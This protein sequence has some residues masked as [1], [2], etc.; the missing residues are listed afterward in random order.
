[1]NRK[2]SVGFMLPIL[3]NNSGGV[4]M[5]QYVEMTIEEA[6]KRC[7]KNK[8]VLVAIQDL[9]DS[10]PV[11]LAFVQKDK[12][13]YPSIFEDVQTVASMCDDLVKQLRLFT[14]KQN[15]LNIKPRG[16]QRIVL[17]QEI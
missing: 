14:E 9:E 2:R 4:V 17:L 16:Q 13:E 3:E 11:N 7:N 1:M 12:S 15:V 6:M 5:Q 10:K 8:K